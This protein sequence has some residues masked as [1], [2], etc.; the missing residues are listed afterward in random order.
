MHGLHTPA[1]PSQKHIVVRKVPGRL[2]FLLTVWHWPEL[3]IQL[4]AATLVPPE[5]QMSSADDDKNILGL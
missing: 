2:P 3:V 4:I 1:L 5:V